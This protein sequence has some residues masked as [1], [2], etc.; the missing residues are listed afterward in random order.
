MHAT[1]TVRLVVL[2]RSY[3]PLVAEFSVVVLRVTSESRAAEK[4]E[5]TSEH[6]VVRRQRGKKA[7]EK[8]V[9]QQERLNGKAVARVEA[10]KLGE[11]TL[12]RLRADRQLKL[13]VP[14]LRGAIT[15]LGAEPKGSLPK[16]KEQLEKLLTDRP[17]V[18]AL[19][20]PTVPPEPPKRIAIRAPRQVARPDSGR[21]PE[22]SPSRRCRRSGMPG[23][24]SG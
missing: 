24:C 1:R 15:K 10:L 21:Q 2:E 9:A 8:E 7:R 6:S 13:K 22:P 14:E 19:P 18:L 23:E 11:A 17:Q 16:L 12:E 5:G 20:A 3:P 4:E